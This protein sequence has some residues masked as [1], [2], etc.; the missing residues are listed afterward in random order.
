METSE[1][2]RLADLIAQKLTRIKDIA[3]KKVVLRNKLDE[4]NLEA[5]T[6]STDL[7]RLEEEVKS[8]KYEIAECL[9]DNSLKLVVGE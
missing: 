5:N 2:S 9:S 3:R 6:I 4:V 8:L 1:T 7:N